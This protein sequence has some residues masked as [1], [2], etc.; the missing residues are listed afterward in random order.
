MIDFLI[1]IKIRRTSFLGS[2]WWRKQ[3]IHS[4]QHVP[5]ILLNYSDNSVSIRSCSEH[6]CSNQ[7]TSTIS[8]LKSL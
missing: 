8:N 3:N 1:K 4:E 7:Q 6:V 5:N 2:G